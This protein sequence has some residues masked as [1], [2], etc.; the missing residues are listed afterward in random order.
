META[1][2]LV[3]FVCLAQVL[4]TLHVI[5]VTDFTNRLVY[6]SYQYRQYMICQCTVHEGI[7]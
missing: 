1:L 5:T 2:I 7:K 4:V 3:D 6:F